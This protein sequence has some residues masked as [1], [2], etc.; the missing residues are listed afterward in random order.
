MLTRCSSSRR[1]LPNLLEMAAQDSRSRTDAHY[2]SFLSRGCLGLIVTLCAVSLTA[3]TA[4]TASAAEPGVNLITVNNAQ[5][6]DT[7]A[8][9]THWVRMFVLWSDFQPTRGSWAEN[10]FAYYENEFRALP[11]NTKVILD[12]VGTP[13]WETGSSDEHTPPANDGEFAQFVATIAA[14][15]GSHV[16]AY[17]IWNEEDA[18][19]WWSGGPNAVAYTELLRA[20]YPAV[21]S[22]SPAASVVLGGLTGNDYEF[23]EAVYR[24]G[25][26]GYFDVVGVHTDTACNDLSPYEYLR[27][28]DNRMIADS[29]LAYREVHSVMVANGDDKPIWMTELSWATTNATCS[30]GAWAGQKPAGVS[31]QQQATY[32]AQAYHCMAQDPYVQVALWFPLQ[33]QDVITRGLVRSNGSRKPS[34]AAM[35]NYVRNGDQLSEPCGV[36]TGPHITVATPGN[37]TSYNG[38]LPIRVSADSSAGVFRITLRVD[39]RLIR[40]FQGYGYPSSLSGYLDWMGA[41]HISPGWHTLTFLAYDR[42]RNVSQVSLRIFHGATSSASSHGHGAASSKGVKHTHHATKHK[43]RKRHRHH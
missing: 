27:G 20:V 15:F 35:Q 25:G 18:S 28:P 32:L 12:V 5:N 23:L 29:F 31:D 17:E 6:A 34:F 3:L 41:K 1:P 21:K 42:M 13:S 38:P 19:R 16:A 36:T 39:G 9:G 14:R 43:R 2:R 24:A 10:W 37:G 33:D 8:L 30:E 7:S 11:P 40:N 26:K 4:A 22:A